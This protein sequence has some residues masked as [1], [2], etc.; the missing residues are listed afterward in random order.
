[1]RWKLI[2]TW[3]VG[4][5]L[6]KSSSDSKPVALVTGASSGIGAVYAEALAEAGYHLILVAR[7]EEKLKAVQSRTGGDILVADLATETGVAQVAACIRETPALD[8]LVNNAGFGTQ[9][10]F[11]EAPLAGQVAMHRLHVMAPVNLTHAALPRMVARN[12]GFIVNVAS[13]AGFGQNPGSISYCATKTW[14]NSFTE[15]LWLELRAAKSN[16]RVQ[17]LCPGFTRS[18]FHDAADLDMS[19]VPEV[20]WHSAENIVESSLNALP[21]NELFVIPGWRYQ[22][23][24]SMQKLLPRELIY[25]ITKNSTAEFRKTKNG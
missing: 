24:V 9:G 23:W 22:A 10:Y 11:W 16:V 14:M 20:L 5:I 18:E 1:M 4:L 12:R 21:G 25:A 13:V 2:V 8:F 7:R 17:A 19:R 3:K 6:E 15:G